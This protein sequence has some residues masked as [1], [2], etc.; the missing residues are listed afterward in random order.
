MGKNELSVSLNIY[1]H[2]DVARLTQDLGLKPDKALNKGEPLIAGAAPIPQS[3]WELKSRLPASRSLEEHVESLLDVLIL[4]KD[5]LAE[6][7]KKY[8]TVIAVGAR[9]NEPNPEVVL[10][11]AVLKNLADLGVSLWLDLYLPEQSVSIVE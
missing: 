7:A 5:E 8:K 2:E 11:P 6:I 1:G 10:E 4:H 3:I 9:Y